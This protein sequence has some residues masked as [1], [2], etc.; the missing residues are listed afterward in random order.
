MRPCNRSL[1]GGRRVL[2]W[3]PPSLRGTQRARRYYNTAVMRFIG[4]RSFAR[5]APLAVV[6]VL[7]CVGIFL[8]WLGH[9]PDSPGF[10]SGV[11][12]SQADQGMNG[13]GQPPT[14]IYPAAIGEEAK[15]GAKVPV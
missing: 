1:P 4:S 11:R 5:S 8:P 14:G 3:P 9:G 10:L 6:A 15:D 13:D 7:L 12:Y 2:L